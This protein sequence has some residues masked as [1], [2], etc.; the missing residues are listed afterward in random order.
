MRNKGQ[1]IKSLPSNVMSSAFQSSPEPEILFLLKESLPLVLLGMPDS[2]KGLLLPAGARHWVSHSNSTLRKAYK[3]L[4]STLAK[5][6]MMHV[7]AE[8]TF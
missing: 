3:D 4:Q 6:Y 2:T 8:P 5:S 1:K 7:P